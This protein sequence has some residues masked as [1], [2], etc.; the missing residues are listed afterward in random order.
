MVNFLQASS[1]VSMK[2]L[3]R[4]FQ[5]LP[6]ELIKLYHFCLPQMV[7]IYICMYV[8]SLAKVQWFA[9]QDPRVF[10][11]IHPF[12]QWILIDYQLR[13]VSRVS[14]FWEYKTSRGLNDHAH[15]IHK[16]C[17]NRINM[18]SAMVKKCHNECL[19]SGWGRTFSRI[20]RESL[21]EELSSGFKPE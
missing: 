1:L 8:F 18:F 13:T 17:A 5:L 14:R 4:A 6:K 10:F 9:N 12:I 7:E 15:I 2:G 20:F 11:F 19:S 3:K 21:S 16:S